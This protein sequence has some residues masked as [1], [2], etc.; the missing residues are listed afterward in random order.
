[1]AASSFLSH[2]TLLQKLPLTAQALSLNATH[3]PNEAQASV[4]SGK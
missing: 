1:M 2:E 4:K 3:P